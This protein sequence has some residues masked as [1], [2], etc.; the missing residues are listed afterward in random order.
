[1]FLQKQLL[2][3]YLRIWWRMTL[4]I[5]RADL[6]NRFAA[7][8]FIFGKLIRFFFFLAFIFLL[9]KQSKFLMGYNLDQIVFFFLTFNIVDITSQLLLRGVYHFRPLIVTGNFDLILI[10]PINPLFASLAS[11]ADVLDLITLFPLLGYT[12]YFLA[13][14]QIPITFLGIILYLLLIF[15]AFIITLSFHILVISVGVLTTEVDHLVWIYRDLS[16]M[17]RFPID[18]YREGIRTFLTFVVPIAVLMTFPAK[19]FMGLLSWQLIGYSLVLAVILL[20]LS[21]RFWDFAL[22]KYSS[23]SS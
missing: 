6:M 12:V 16:S 2:S 7:G 11:H 15:C 19:A 17:G 22:K 18:I 5:F 14:G 20:V 4:V 21:L 3:R 13:Q 9:V 23:A 1:M 8:L 10:K